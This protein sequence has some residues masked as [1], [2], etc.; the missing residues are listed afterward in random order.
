MSKNSS[1]KIIINYIDNKSLVIRNA[2][3]YVNIDDNDD[4]ALVDS[5]AV[6]AYDKTVIKINDIDTNKQFYLFLFNTNVIV[7]NKEIVINT[8]NKEMIYKKSN[9]AINNKQQINELNEK[10]KYFNSLQ[11]IGLSLDQY[12]EWNNLKRKL[13][14]ENIKHNLKLIG[15]NNYENQK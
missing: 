8:F 11:T 6:M 2:E 12:I 14:I 13:Y 4:W 7:Y 5:D 1:F 15:E 10:I 9:K 3:L